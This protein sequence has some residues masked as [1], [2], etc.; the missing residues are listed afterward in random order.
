[1]RERTRSPRAPPERSRPP[2]AGTAR[3]RPSLACGAAGPGWTP[4]TS[5]PASLSWPATTTFPP[6][7]EFL[8]RL[9]RTGDARLAYTEALIL[10]GNQAERDFLEHRRSQ[11]GAVDLGPDSRDG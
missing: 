9:P 11:L 2:A 5:S 6:R 8:R 3:S 7:D 1:M 4:S 10:A